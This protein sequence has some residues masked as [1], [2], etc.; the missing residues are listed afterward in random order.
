M[1]EVPRLLH[2]SDPRFGVS[3]ASKQIVLFPGDA[4]LLAGGRDL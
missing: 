2:K 3:L 4:L 1:T